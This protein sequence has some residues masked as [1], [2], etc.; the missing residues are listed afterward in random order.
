MWTLFR[1]VKRTGFSQETL[2]SVYRDHGVIPKDSRDDNN[3]KPSDDLSTYQLVNCDDL[4]INKMKAWQGSVDI[5]KYRGIVSPAYFVMAPLHDEHPSYLNYLLRSVPY[6]HGYRLISSGVRPSQWDLDPEQHSRMS[7]LLPPTG[8]QAAIAAFLDRETGK[9]D[10]LVAEQERLMALLKEKRQAVISQAVTRG[11]NPNAKMKPSGVEWLGEV[12]EHWTIGPLKRFWTV[13]DCKHL[14]AEY[15]TEGWPLASIREVQS[16]FVD[17]SEAKQTTETFYQS[18]IEGG[19]KPLP[20]DL[21]FS[22]NATVGEVAQVT[23]N[24]PPF[25]MGQDVC[26][27]RRQDD[28]LSPDYLQA[29][30]DSDV[31]RQQLAVLMVGSTFKR[32]NVEEIRNLVVPMPPAAEQAAIANALAIEAHT[33]DQVICAATGAIT[34]LK[35]RRAA[36]ISAAVTGKIDLRDAVTTEAAAA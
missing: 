10:A 5:S 22:R 13:T 23:T 21:I 2:L 25:A 4:V 29:V 33:A 34:L 36:L 32:V 15:V 18:L 12:P 27:L 17:L 16:R 26:L 30:I 14:T 20:G 6:T 9:I 7:V 8:E 28:R 1:R 31:V 19:R 3:N 11:R 24:H 35:E